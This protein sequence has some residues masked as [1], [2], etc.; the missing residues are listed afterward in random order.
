M[1]CSLFIVISGSLS[2]H[3][4]QTTSGTQKR[5]IAF[6]PG[7]VLGEMA[8]ITGAPRSANAL[9]DEDSELMELDNT[10]IERLGVDKP[11]LAIAIMRNLSALLADRLR[12]TTLQFSQL[13]G[14]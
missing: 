10:V 7:A 8:V 6:G 3:L 5:L 13:A 1:G 4:P 11:E 12:T 2:I 9:A 14:D